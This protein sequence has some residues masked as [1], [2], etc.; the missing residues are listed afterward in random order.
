MQYINNKI[1]R[2]QLNILNA[3]QKIIKIII[4]SEFKNKLF[5]VAR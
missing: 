4:I 2:I 1:I 3:L 5:F